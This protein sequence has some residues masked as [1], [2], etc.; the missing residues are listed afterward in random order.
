MLPNLRAETLLLCTLTA[1]PLLLVQPNPEHNPYLALLQRGERESCMLTC[2]WFI[3][4]RSERG[5]MTSFTAFCT[6]SGDTV[7]RPSRAADA[8]ATR[9][10]HSKNIILV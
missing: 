9:T 10:W 7:S 4:L 6:S 8:F 2:G 5:N 1:A 3:W